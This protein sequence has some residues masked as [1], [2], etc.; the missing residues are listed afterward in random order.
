V[1]VPSKVA[2]DIESLEVD[3]EVSDNNNASSLDDFDFSEMGE[4]EGELLIEDESA[5]SLDDFGFIGEDENKELE[6]DNEEISI[7]DL[8]TDFIFEEDETKKDSD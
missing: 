2:N 8:E 5:S 7:D 6:I 4:L 1:V 3:F